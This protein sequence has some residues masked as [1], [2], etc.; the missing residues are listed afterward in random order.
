MVLALVAVALS[1]YYYLKRSYDYFEKRGIPYKKPLPLL[2]NTWRAM[3]KLD[4]FVQT[5]TDLYNINR[6]AKY[7]GFYEFMLPM[8]MIRDVDLAKQIMVKHFD[9]F[10]DHR[11]F[12]EGDTESLFSKN[13]F[14]LRGERWKEVRNVLTPVFTSSKMKAMF[15]LM[16]ECAEK[17]G[18]TLS[19]LT[20]KERVLDLKEIF[21]RYVSPFIC[22]CQCKDGNVEEGFVFF[23][24][25]FNKKHQAKG[26]SLDS[27]LTVFSV[28]KPAIRFRRW[29]YRQIVATILT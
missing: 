10:R 26:K 9:H 23:R 13:L 16:T 28:Y 15:K 1:A 18:N 7:I 24:H 21:T 6:D 5:I 29:A 22:S 3:F 4:T 11:S 17:Y 8:I 20:E 12:Q 25:L 19:N 2:G 27:M 14:V